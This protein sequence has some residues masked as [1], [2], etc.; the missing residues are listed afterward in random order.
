MKPKLARILTEVNEELDARVE[1]TYQDAA[2][3][4]GEVDGNRVEAAV[5]ATSIGDGC[6]DGE[7]A[8]HGIENDAVRGESSRERLGALAENVVERHREG[9]AT[10]RGGVRAC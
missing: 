1:G 6:C 2:A 9:V 7:G 5:C 4:I 3:T 8:E 10:A